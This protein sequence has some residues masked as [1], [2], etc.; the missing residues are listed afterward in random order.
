MAEKRE[1]WYKQ[2]QSCR[3]ESSNECIELRMEHSKLVY[4]SDGGCAWNQQLPDKVKVDRGMSRTPFLDDTD[5]AT[6]VCTR[7]Q[8]VFLAFR[9]FMV[10]KDNKT[11][12]KE[13][14]CLVR[15]DKKFNRQPTLHPDQIGW[16]S[17]PDPNQW[18]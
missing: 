15:S 16:E 18:V 8:G 12:R 1:C 13:T 2:G 11:K 17:Y 4:C 7:G 9:E 6:G 14:V 3:C 10:E 5:Y